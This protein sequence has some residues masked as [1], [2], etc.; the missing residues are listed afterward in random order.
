M[1]TITDYQVLSGGGIILDASTGINERTFIWKV[2]PNMVMGTDLAKPI[3]AFWV[4]P[5]TNIA[6]TFFVNH[7]EVFTLN[8]VKSSVVNLFTPFSASTAFPENTSF[9]NDTPVRLRVSDGRVDFANIMMW[10]QVRV[11]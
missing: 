6:F 4:T 7:R 11:D 2:P 10:Y 1:M 3:L 9:S 8:M 5:L